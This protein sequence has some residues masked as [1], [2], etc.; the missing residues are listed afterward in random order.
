MATAV[1]WLAV[2]GTPP[3]EPQRAALKQKLT[4]ARTP[5]RWRASLTAYSREAVLQR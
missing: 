2:M 5:S 3:V 1:V 4:G